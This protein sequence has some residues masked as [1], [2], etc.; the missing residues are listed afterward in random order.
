MFCQKMMLSDVIWLVVV[1]KIIQYVC[2]KDERF[3]QPEDVV[4]VC[5]I[6][7]LHSDC[8]WTDSVAL[9]DNV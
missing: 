5:V 3:S 7:Y 8:G 9:W 4:H 2:F 6:T 1:I